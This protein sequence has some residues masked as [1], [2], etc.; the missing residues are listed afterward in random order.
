MNGAPTQL[1]A[2]EQALILDAT[3]LSILF[4]RNPNEQYLHCHCIYQEWSDDLEIY[5]EIINNTATVGAGGGIAIYLS[6]NDG[7]R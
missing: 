6:N 5:N 7:D 2:V 4:L 1:L 3:F